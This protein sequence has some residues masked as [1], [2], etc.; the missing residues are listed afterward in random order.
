MKRAVGKEF[1]LA[2][3]QVR[4]MKL[5]S[6]KDPRPKPEPFIV[7]SYTIV[8]GRQTVR[9]KRGESNR[10][11]DYMAIADS[12]TRDPDKWLDDQMEKH[13]ERLRHNARGE[14]ANLDREAAQEAQAA[15][16]EAKAIIRDDSNQDPRV[17]SARASINPAYKAKVERAAILIQMEA[18]A[19]KKKVSFASL[20]ATAKAANKI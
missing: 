2:E 13:L 10:S 3:W 12:Y 9:L 20:Y 14:R 19:Q 18:E 15:L 17:R 1:G 7:H 4:N 6:S 11:L 5:G 8:D 16:S